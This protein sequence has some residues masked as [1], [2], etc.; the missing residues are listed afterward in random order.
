MV[1]ARSAGALGILVL[2]GETTMQQAQAADPAPDLVV[3]DVGELTRL[4]MSG[5]DA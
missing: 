3:N 4:L 2:S 1:M 5:R